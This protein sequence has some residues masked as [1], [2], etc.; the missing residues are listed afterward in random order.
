MNLISFKMPK[1]YIPKFMKMSFMNYVYLLEMVL[2]IFERYENAKDI[3]EH[4]ELI[5]E[6]ETI[7]E[8][9]NILEIGIIRFIFVN[10]NVRFY[11]KPNLNVDTYYTNHKEVIF[12]IISKNIHFP[13]GVNPIYLI[14]E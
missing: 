13:T 9:P 3:S 7:F 1:I 2:N 12:I 10:N 11:L 14:I 4:I 6:I 5:Q 8:F